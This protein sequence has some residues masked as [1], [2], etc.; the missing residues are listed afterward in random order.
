MKFKIT[1]VGVFEYDVN[2]ED[3]PN[4]NTPE[5][6]LNTDIDTVYE[7]PSPFIQDWQVTGQIIDLNE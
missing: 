1:V 5:E 3:Y 2:P 7:D 6:M 4:D